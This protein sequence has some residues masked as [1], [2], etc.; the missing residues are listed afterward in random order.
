MYV[1]KKLDEN[2]NKNYTTLFL[3]NFDLS[4]K[5]TKQHNMID[6]NVNLTK[7]YMT[8]HNDNHYNGGDALCDRFQKSN[9]NIIIN[10]HNDDNNTNLNN[11]DDF[12]L[13][14]FAK[15]NLMQTP[16][17]PYAKANNNNNNNEGDNPNCG[18]ES[19]VETK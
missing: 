15:N 12:F 11:G 14:S 4:F 19:L 7:I 2:C 10:N 18:S 17:S 5:T 6:G 3:N 1:E 8:K 13:P 16:P 9:N